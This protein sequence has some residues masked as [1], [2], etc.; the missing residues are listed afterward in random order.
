[1]PYRRSSDDV[2]HTLAAPLY[3]F[4]LLLVVIPVVDFVQS[5]GT[6]Q[7]GNIQW[8]FATVGL[9]S[10]VLLTPMLGLGIA[11]VVAAFRRH[12]RALRLLAL[13]SALAAIALMLLTLG[14]TLDVL[15]LRNSVPAQGESAFRGASVKAVLKHLAAA[16]VLGLLGVRAWR[17]SAWRVS[18]AER[19]PVPLVSR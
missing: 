9:L 18:A 16:F 19:T 11:I 5:V 12:L 15:Q 2:Q 1:M 6:P 14:F 10:S 4:A 13:L 8:R 7:P 3:A 17:L